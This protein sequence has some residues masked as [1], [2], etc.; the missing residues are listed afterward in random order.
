MQSIMKFSWCVYSSITP[1]NVFPTSSAFREN[2]LTKSNNLTSC[3]RRSR[4]EDL[5]RDKL[6]TK[7]INKSYASPLLPSNKEEIFPGKF[8]RYLA[9]QRIYSFVFDVLNRVRIKLR[10][11]L[12][13]KVNVEFKRVTHVNFICNFSLIQIQLSTRFRS[14]IPT[15]SSLSIYLSL[16]SISRAQSSAFNFSNFWNERIKFVFISFKI[17]HKF[18]DIFSHYDQFV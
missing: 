1:G 17:T 14:N 6:E 11:L 9:R 2:Y 7:F 12:R 18:I 5:H 10:A 15:D 4:I 16:W 13:V 3:L 8:S